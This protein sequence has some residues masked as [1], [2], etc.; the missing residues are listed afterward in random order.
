MG[1]VKR[2]VIGAVIGLLVASIF[3]ADTLLFVFVGFVFGWFLPG[4]KKELHGK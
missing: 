3:K 1:N 4:I 2:A